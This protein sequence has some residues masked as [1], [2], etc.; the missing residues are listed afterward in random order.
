MMS[1]RIETV[2]ELPQS[3]V[4]LFTELVGLRGLPIKTAV[5]FSRQKPGKQAQL[6]LET[7]E[8]GTAVQTDSCIETSTKLVGGW[9]VSNS[10][11][12]ELYRLIEP[13]I[14]SPVNYT[15][16]EFRSDTVFLIARN[17]FIFVYSLK[18]KDTT[19]V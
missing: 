19:Q 17:D 12:E 2:P 15:S 10:Y 4:R 11:I 13:L 18:P 6:G 14:L 5:V 3:T 16:L 9:N 8:T 1:S 7:S